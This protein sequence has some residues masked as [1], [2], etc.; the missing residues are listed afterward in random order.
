[1]A[2]RVK[3]GDGG[4]CDASA[5]PV[6]RDA[7]NYGVGTAVFAGVAGAA[8]G[9]M[10]DRSLPPRR[11]GSLSIAPAPSP[12]F[13]PMAELAPSA[14]DTTAEVRPATSF[15]NAISIF[16]GGVAGVG[17]Y[18][19]LSQEFRGPCPD[20]PETQCPAD[21]IPVGWRLAGAAVSGTAGYLVTRGITGAWSKPR[22]PSAVEVG[23]PRQETGLNWW[24][25]GIVGAG[26]G[27]LTT[28]FLAYGL[29]AG[30]ELEMSDGQ[31][32]LV[33]A[34]LG[35]LIGFVVGGSHAQGR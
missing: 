8:L 27:A 7:L 2:G 29:H 32:A 11:T 26:V 30:H 10:V 28:S 23:V 35:A 21:R 18:A 16:G 25:G 14:G 1:M 4:L 24:Q 12:L 5:P 34:P 31:A 19:F 20:S 22:T 33:I 3:S 9:Y 17:A 6:C 15:Q 13:A